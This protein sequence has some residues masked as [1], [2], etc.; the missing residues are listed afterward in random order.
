[1]TL[2]NPKYGTAVQALRHTLKMPGLAS[3]SRPAW[4]VN[5]GPGPCGYSCQQGGAGSA[6]TAYSNTWALGPLK[7]GKTR[8]STG[9]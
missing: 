2:T 5:R 4:V 1:M 8:R 6:V 3:H 9:Q 7:P